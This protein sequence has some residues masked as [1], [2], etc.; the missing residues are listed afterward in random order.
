MNTTILLAITALV[1]ALGLLAAF[2]I[3]IPALDGHIAL[4]KLK[5]QYLVFI[6]FFIKTFM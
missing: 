5:T 6:I 2:T 4:A 3:A 1:V